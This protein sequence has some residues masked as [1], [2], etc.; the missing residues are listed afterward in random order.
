MRTKNVSALQ[1]WGKQQLTVLSTAAGTLKMTDM[2]WFRSRSI[3]TV[4]IR[5]AIN[6]RSVPVSFSRK[7]IPEHKGKKRWGRFLRTQ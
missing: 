2:I 3:N 5:F 1:G 6:L 7:K 4:A